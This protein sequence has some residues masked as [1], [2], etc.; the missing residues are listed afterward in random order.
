VELD[1]LWPDSGHSPCH[2]TYR[3]RAES[4][5][6]FLANVPEGEHD[7]SIIASNT[8]YLYY[9]KALYNGALEASRRTRF[10]WRPDR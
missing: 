5:F 6:S 10:S 9:V 1:W 4:T 3:A 8:G 7:D 2:T